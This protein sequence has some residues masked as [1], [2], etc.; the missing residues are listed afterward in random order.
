MQ[1]QQHLTAQTN[2]K[3]RTNRNKQ[4]HGRLWKQEI[5]IFF[6]KKSNTYSS[7]ELF[8]LYEN[9]IKRKQK[10]VEFDQRSSLHVIVR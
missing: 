1:Q 7:I 10:L 3:E 8:P 4:I 2:K 6:F 5:R 9:K